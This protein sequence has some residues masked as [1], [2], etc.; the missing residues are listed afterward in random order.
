[1]LMKIVGGMTIAGG[2]A[3]IGELT[4]LA[5]TSEL[6]PTNKRGLWVGLMVFTILPWTPSI[7]YAQLV[8]HAGGFRYVG[9]LCGLWSFVGLVMTVLFYHPPPRPNLSGYDKK[10]IIKRVDFIGGFFSICGV[11]LFLAGLQWGGY[12]V[13]LDPSDS[14]SVR[15]IVT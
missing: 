8:N 13:S 9:L 12:Q 4:A 15:L 1:M 2:G 3:G 5:G 11:I 10:E 7:M 14:N 6:A